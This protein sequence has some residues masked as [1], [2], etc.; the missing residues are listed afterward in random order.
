VRIHS[1]T[2]ALLA[3]ASTAAL[4]AYAGSPSYLCI[5]D[6]STGFSMNKHGGW[7]ATSFRTGRYVIRVPDKGPD[8]PGAAEHSAMAVYNFG[9]NEPRDYIYCT[10]DFNAAGYLFCKGVQERFS[11]NRKTLRFVH[12]FIDGYIDPPHQGLSESDG[13]ARPFIEIGTCSQI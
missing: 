9:D 4:T 8:Q 10:D 3:M 6:Q 7:G 2:A 5:G 12:W 1:L 13:S 11:F